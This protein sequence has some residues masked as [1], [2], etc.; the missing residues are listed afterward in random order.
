MSGPGSI[1]NRAPFRGRR[2]SSRPPSRQPQQACNG[3]TNAAQKADCIF[4]VVVTGET[5]FAQSYE[6]MQRFRPHGTGWQPVLAVQAVAAAAAT[7]PWWLWILIGILV[8]LVI[9]VLIA[10]KRRTA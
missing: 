5:G 7:W 3:V 2:P 6:A 4:D 1:H 10:K 9:A 8:L